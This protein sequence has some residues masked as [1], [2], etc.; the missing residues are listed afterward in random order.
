MTT[1]NNPTTN[2]AYADGGASPNPGASGAGVYLVRHDGTTE[3]T[4][5]PLGFGTNQKAEL[6]AIQ[7]ACEVAPLD[8]PLLIV[9]DSKYAIGMVSQGWNANANQAEVAA[10]KGALNARTAPTSFEWV[11]GHQGNEGNEKA[12]ALATKARLGNTTPN[13]K[14]PGGATNTPGATNELPTDCTVSTSTPMT[15][16]TLTTQQKDYS[17]AL[18]H[19]SFEVQRKYLSDRAVPPEYALSKGVRWAVTDRKASY[20]TGTLGALP[21][22]VVDPQKVSEEYKFGVH[23]DG[24][25]FGYRYNK[26]FTYARL[27]NLEA[28]YTVMP[29]NQAEMIEKCEGVAQVK[30]LDRYMAP[31]GKECPPYLS[32]CSKAGL[33]DPTQP[34]IIVEGPAKALALSHHTGIETIALGGVFAGWADKSVKLEFGL[35]V[36]QSDLALIGWKGRTVTIIFDAG[37]QQNPSVALAEA[38][39]AQLLR[40]EGAVVKLAELPLFKGE[41]QGPDDYIARNGADAMKA[42]L[43]AAIP[44]GLDLAGRK[45]SERVVELPFQAALAV[46][47]E[48]ERNEFAIANKKCGVTPKALREAVRALQEASSA[49]AQ[50]QMSK[51]EKFCEEGGVICLQTLAGASPLCNFSARIMKD[52]DLDDG[53]ERKTVFEIEGRDQKGKLL[54]TARVEAKDFAKLEWILPSFRSG[55]IIESGRETKDL[56]RQAIQELSCPVSE[57]VYSHTGWRQVAGKW[58]YL[59]AGGSVSGATDLRVDLGANLKNFK[60]PDESSDVKSD[61]AASFEMLRLAAPTIMMP[62]LAATYLAPLA[63]ILT[64]DFMLW[65]NGPSGSF[66]SEIATLCQAHFGA[67]KRTT[68]PG[69]WTSTANSLENLLFTLKDSLTVID[70]YA[71]QSTLREQQRL[72]EAAHRIIRALGN[73]SG[74]GR[75]TATC[76]QRVTRTPRGAVIATGE[77][78]PAHGT[79]GGSILARLVVVEVDKPQVNPDVLTHIQANGGALARCM[80]AFIAWLAPQYEALQTE[81]PKR[82]DA[83]R[84]QFMALNAGHARAPEALATL[85]TALELFLDFCEIQ[86]VS[87]HLGRSAA[88]GADMGYARDKIKDCLSVVSDRQSR[89]QAATEPGT[90]FVEILSSLFD[91]RRVALQAEKKS[92]LMQSREC[93][94]IGWVD[95]ASAYVLPKEA[96]RVVHEYLRSTNEHW[97]ATDAALVQSLRAKG[98]VTSWSNGE[99]RA[100]PKKSLGSGSVRVWQMPLT[101]LTEADLTSDAEAAAAVVDTGKLSRAFEESAAPLH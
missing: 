78:L 87:T 53:A 60:F 70:D 98:Y 58:D 29:D 73:G 12:D 16:S 38:R 85:A 4:S 84:T 43:A 2:T 41:D 28:S 65:V 100:D 20:L 26:E 59:F 45:G 25:L 66:K 47:T 71:P 50:E 86:G 36:L 46:A 27:R 62:L 97:T 67:F 32:C 91:S 92:D 17:I 19:P 94:Q 77:Q 3:S 51:R 10:A 69:S 82:R 37:R 1:T 68:L 81:L 14:N 72:I 52:I 9:T 57:T 54:G 76:E 11:K 89:A 5:K 74:R 39:L 55:A 8:E 22:G 80:R 101:C 49:K 23:G 61:V 18:N 90:R 35:E 56:L 40:R 30:T 75:L 96:L 31:A 99:K 64:P 88:T 34:L 33:S 21:T 63:S 7:I 83:W 42:L 79:N 93:P 6:A 24:L 15:S 48:L 95:G 44:S 13:V